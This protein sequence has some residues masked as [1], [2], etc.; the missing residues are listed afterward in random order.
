MNQQRKETIIKALKE[1]GVSLP[2][3]RCKSSNF[4]VV[5]QTTLSMSENPSIVSL[6]GM[7]VPAALIACSKCGFIT[8]HALGS[9]GLMPNS[10]AHHE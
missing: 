3:P 8:L 9:L 1:K 2:C 7:V 5:G 10:Q 6:G 4:Q